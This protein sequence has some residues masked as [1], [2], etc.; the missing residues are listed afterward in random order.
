MYRWNWLRLLYLFA[1][2]WILLH[3]FLLNGIG[4]RVVHEYREADQAEGQGR[5]SVFLPVDTSASEYLFEPKKK[6]VVNVC[7]G[8]V[9][10]HVY[11]SCDT[12]LPL[13]EFKGLLST[14]L[15]VINKQRLDKL[16]QL[17][18]GASR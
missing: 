15:L 8:L 16:D 17:L 4:I 9:R 1:V 10:D 3:L 12:L 2:F 7:I 13:F 6:V 11:N 18:D 14:T 5:I